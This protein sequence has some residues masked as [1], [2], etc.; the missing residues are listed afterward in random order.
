MAESSREFGRDIHTRPRAMVES[1]LNPVTMPSRSLNDAE[2][3][4]ISDVATRHGLLYAA[5][6]GGISGA[7]VFAANALLPRFR[8]LGT[9]AKAALVVTPTSGAFFAKSHLEVARAT[10]DPNS[11]VDESSRAAGDAPMASGPLPLWQRAANI[12]YEHPFKTIV[13]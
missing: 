8:G 5:V 12:V 2:T 10:K 4:R 11:Y 1:A 7:L 13:G 6:A 3:S 9:S